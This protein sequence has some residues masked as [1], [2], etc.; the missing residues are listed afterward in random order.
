MKSGC[1][2]KSP[3]SKNLIVGCVH[4]K[5]GQA[6]GEHTTGARE[7]LLIF[8][9]GKAMVMVGR[10]QKILQAGRYFYIKPNQIHN[11]INKFKK[12]VEYLYITAKV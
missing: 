8:L 6:V 10:R 3:K 1:V 11:V 9:K 2:I 5:A 4:L 7:E 12:P